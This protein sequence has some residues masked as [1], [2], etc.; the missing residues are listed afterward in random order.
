[1]KETNKVKKKGK[2]KINEEKNSQKRGT[3]IF[4]F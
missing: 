4:K 3:P 2:C 1:M